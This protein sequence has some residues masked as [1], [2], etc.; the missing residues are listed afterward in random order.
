MGKLPRD[1]G[2]DRSSCLKLTHQ[3]IRGLTNKI[4][5]LELFVCEENP[6]LLCLTEHSLK[7][8]QIENVVIQNYKL[9]S[10]FCRSQK[11]GGGVSI[12]SRPEIDC[13]EITCRQFSIEGICE[14]A[15]VSVK[16]YNGRKLL[17]LA[18][19]RPPSNDIDQFFE[20]M[21]E[22]LNTL[23]KNHSTVMVIGDFNIDLSKDSLT[24]NKFS[25][26][27]ASYG[28]NNVV[29]HYTREAFG[30]QSLIDHVFT[31]D[32]NTVCS[33]ITSGLSDH[34]AQSA[35]INCHPV[36][37]QIK[38]TSTEIRTFNEI[39]MK[40]FKYLLSNETWI[41]MIDARDMDDKYRAFSTQLKQ[42]FDIS[43]PLK[44]KK[45]KL[46]NT[47]N[48][49]LPNEILQLKIETREL[50]DKTKHLSSSHPLRQYYLQ[51]K[52]LYR[53][54]IR[55]AKSNM[56]QEQLNKSDNKTKTIWKIINK[57]RPAKILKSQRNIILE[58]DGELIEHPL[59]VANTFN[60]YFANVGAAIKNP[61]N[62]D[63]SIDYHREKMILHSLFLSPVNEEEIKQQVE[64]L[65]NKK[66]AGY[67]HITAPV[68]KYVIDELTE[69]L[70]HLVN[71][72]FM[73]GKFPNELK[74]S[75]V[76]PIFKEGEKQ[77]CGNYR[78]ISITS[79]I[80]KIFEK[81]ILTRMLKFLVKHNILSP[82]QHGFIK[83]KNTTTAIFSLL[84]HVVKELDIGKCVSGLFFDLSKAF[85]TVN[86]E[87]LCSMMYK[88]GVRGVALDWFTSYLRGR[89]QVVE[90]IS[91]DCSGCLRRLLSPEVQVLRGVPQGSILGPLLFLIYVNDLS[92]G[93]SSGKICQFADDTSLSL[94]S[95]N[96]Q[97]LEQISFIES[98]NL[99]QW[100][101][102][103]L[104]LIN[105]K[106]T[107]LI[108]FSVSKT[109]KHIS[110]FNVILDETIIY[111]SD[112]VKF[113]GILVDERLKF[114]AHVDYVSRK[115]S[116]GTFMLRNLAKTVDSDVLLSAYYGL[117]YP[118]LAY[119]V[120][121]W[122]NENHRTRFLFRLQKKAIRVIFFLKKHQSCKEFF[123]NFKVLTFPALYILETLTFIKVNLPAFSSFIN[124]SYSL[125]DNHS[126]R[127]PRHCTAF[128]ERHTL[129]N[130]VA[131]YNCLPLSL[132][133]ETC[134]LKFKKQL[135][136][137][138][139]D[140]CC[141]SVREF[142]TGH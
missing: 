69:P 117:V 10:Y 85:D 43:F 77:F 80:S 82:S 105:T 109:K 60:N 42:Y 79:T 72:S 21:C 1:V 56:F 62:I 9:Q 45:Y 44:R 71:H 28:L 129:Y 17:L 30:S 57:I 40:T 65:K 123:R 138:L 94:S 103:N 53:K 37:E 4:E 46:N 107:H 102:E 121:I 31:S 15:A 59:D 63:V 139:L 70:K 5:L 131:L 84:N 29:K 19:Y 68:I 113:L 89:R 127:V 74:L 115:V 34:Y 18:V 3:N 39:N 2:V 100:F 92:S 54:M 87:L 112:K 48:V 49:K 130:G 104:L 111:P 110:P 118:Y 73:T 88:L 64:A 86:H 14:L 66:S 47:K 25:S 22:T 55:K 128:F 134:H 97:S 35:T 38:A 142:Q 90:F 52:D 81:L 119:A 137:L 132:K 91:V 106:K 78:P 96:I 140:L 83:K 23:E 98:N 51:R 116:I 41:E 101:Q 13:R 33:V 24:A 76:K 125:R 6:D 108:Q 12:W 135:K 136:A 67:D 8:Y 7:A 36:E 20:T 58:T 11:K 16:L 93:V 133:L 114:Y 32:K 27:M 50:Y 99:L 120:P 124:H 61:T 75:I 26:I 126:L 141:Y 122:G 95:H